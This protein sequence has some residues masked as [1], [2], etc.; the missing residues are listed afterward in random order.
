[1]WFW[2]IVRRFEELEALE[3]EWLNLAK[4]RTD[5]YKYFF[6]AGDS[7][8]NNQTTMNQR[9]GHQNRLLR[10]RSAASLIGECQ[11]PPQKG[12]WTGLGKPLRKVLRNIEIG[13]EPSKHD[14]PVFKVSQYTPSR[15][16]CIA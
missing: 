15:G 9:G 16:G 1:M 6:G 8:I 13:V 14:S 4:Q 11:L 12:Y 10:I 3:A 2:S 7:F 5:L